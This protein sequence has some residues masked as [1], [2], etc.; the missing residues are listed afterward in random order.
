MTVSL[1]T[2]AGAGFAAFLAA[3]HRPAAA[4]LAASAKAFDE[5]MTAYVQELWQT[6]ALRSMA[7]AA[8]QLAPLAFSFDVASAS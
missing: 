7:R 2:N 5:A 6:D 8:A 4:V 1:R 3:T